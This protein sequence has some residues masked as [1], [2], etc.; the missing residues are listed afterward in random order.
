MQNVLEIDCKKW[1]KIKNEIDTRYYEFKILK[2]P[3]CDDDSYDNRV[4][5]ISNR[6][7]LILNRLQN[8][9][10]HFKVSQSLYKNILFYNF[11]YIMYK[12]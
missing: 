6:W 8:N 7:S 2:D 10:I 11:I 4:D 3:L 5:I 12:I 1:G 9:L